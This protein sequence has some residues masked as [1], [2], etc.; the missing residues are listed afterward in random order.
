MLHSI[1]ATYLSRILSLAQ[2]PCQ[3]FGSLFEIQGFAK[4]NQLLSVNGVFS[5]RPNYWPIDRTETINSPLRLALYRTWQQPAQASTLD[6]SLYHRVTELCTGNEVCNILW[7]GGIDSTTV[8]TA[9]LRFA[10]DLKQVRVL[11]SPWSEYEHPGYV[12]WIKTKYPTLDIVDISGDVYI[13]E[14]FDGLLITGDG[15]DE[16]MASL[17]ESF[18]SRTGFETLNKP[19][20]DYFFQ[21]LG[22]KGSDLIDF[23]DRFCML[24]GRPIDSLLEARWW[25]YQAVKAD[26]IL[27]ETKIQLLTSDSNKIHHQRLVGFFDCDQFLAF[28]Y[29]NLDKI[30]TDEGYENWKKCL[31]RFCF[32]H[33]GFNDWYHKKIKYN[34]LQLAKYFRKKIVLSDKR[35][36][37]VLANGDKITTPNLPFLNQIDLDEYCPGLIAN[38]I[39][40]AD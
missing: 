16:S 14:K 24:S 39:N 13:H 36:I 3:T 5:S 31:K 38:I 18:Y 22:P 23:Y 26:S 2:V 1:N 11:Y 32:E 10:P 15:G 21:L 33:D 25:Y 19:W 28:I 29:F 27:R 7:S 20:K 35:W 40:D 6:D 9:F 34:S 8:L 30:I 37:A 17:D 12:S 4:Y